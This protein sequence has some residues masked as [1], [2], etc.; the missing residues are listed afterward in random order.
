MYIYRKRLSAIEYQYK[1]HWGYYRSFT[2]YIW[3][4]ALI[5]NNYD[6]AY[7]AFLNIVIPNIIQKCVDFSHFFIQY[8]GYFYD[9]FFFIC[10]FIS[11]KHSLLI[12]P[13]HIFYIKSN[14]SYHNYIYVIVFRTISCF[15]RIYYF[16]SYSFEINNV[17]MIMTFIFREFFIILL[18]IFIILQ[19]ISFTIKS[20]NVK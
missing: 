17:I 12:Y 10:I 13:N 11:F 16:G 14:H 5:Y 15:S 3:V 4:I 8:K 1:F 9:F 6:F 20:K 2:V 18:R 7:S 19:R